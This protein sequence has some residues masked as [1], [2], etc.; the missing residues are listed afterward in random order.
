MMTSFYKILKPLAVAA[1]ALFLSMSA[2]A[3]VLSLTPSTLGVIAADLGSSNCEAG[4]IYTA[5]GLTNA[6]GTADDL[7]LYYKADVSPAAES[8]S[9]ASSYET[10]FANTSTDPADALIDYISGA[11]ISCPECYLAI[12]D[13]N[14]N[15]SYYFY[16]LTGWNGTDDISMTG[17]WPQQGAIS[18]VSIWGR[19]DDGGSGG[20][21]GGNAPEPGSLALVGLALVGAGVIRKR[22][23]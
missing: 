1:G 3:A 12:K 17:F 7:V 16:N 22:V 23:R 14:Q 11:S 20:G 13:G 21:G 8:G 9:F 18:H 4:C 5:F 10:T 6:P 2:Q 19:A 15:P